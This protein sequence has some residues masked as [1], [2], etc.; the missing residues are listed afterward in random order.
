[1]AGQKHRLTREPWVQT[2]RNSS[3][4]AHMRRKR[5]DCHAPSPQRR[6]DTSGTA[7]VGE[8]HDGELLPVTEELFRLRLHE[9]HLL[10]LLQKRARLFRELP[11]VQ[12]QR[13]YAATQLAA[14]PTSHAPR[15]A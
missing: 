11:G 8:T 13:Q 4:A 3:F 14:K 15:G 12:L 2:A 10:R 9:T 7:A 5:C 6:G 1:M